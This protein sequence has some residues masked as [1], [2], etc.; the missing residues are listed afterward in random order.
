MRLGSW[1]PKDP[2]HLS[3]EDMFV[4][5]CYLLLIHIVMR[6]GYIVWT[7]ILLLPLLAAIACLVT[8]DDW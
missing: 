2:P 6:A 8:W 7:C 1:Q 3:P 5:L 4:I